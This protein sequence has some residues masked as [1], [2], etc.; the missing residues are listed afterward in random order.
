MTLE[1]EHK[2]ILLVQLQLTISYFPGDMYLVI[3]NSC[4]AQKKSNNNNKLQFPSCWKSWLS[5]TIENRYKVGQKPTANCC[6]EFQKRNVGKA[7][8]PQHHCN[9]DTS[10]GFLRWFCSTFSGWFLLFTQNQRKGTGQRLVLVKAN[11]L[12]PACR[13]LAEQREVAHQDTGLTG[14]A[15]RSWPRPAEQDVHGFG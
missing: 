6:S 10:R 7:A 5:K 2:S 15:G 8:G 14:W 4:R 3:P 13:G 9:Q 12:P 11:Q 1:T